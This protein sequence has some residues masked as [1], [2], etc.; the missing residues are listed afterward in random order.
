MSDSFVGT[1][2][3]IEGGLKGAEAL[4][5]GSRRTGAVDI[6]IY[7]RKAGGWNRI[8]G[9]RILTRMKSGILIG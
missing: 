1:I 4:Y 6:H 2:Y 9:G 7:T 8:A 5:H 3:R